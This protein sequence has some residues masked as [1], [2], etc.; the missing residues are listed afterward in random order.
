M[1]TNGGTKKTPKLLVNCNQRIAPGS[2]RLLYAAVAM[3]NPMPP[4]NRELRIMTRIKE[5]AILTGLHE[6]WF[7]IG[8]YFCS[9][10]KD[11]RY[12]DW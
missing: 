6:G 3:M 2:A 10:G 9:D 12:R 11:R 4:I 1:N 5:A 7:C 8:L